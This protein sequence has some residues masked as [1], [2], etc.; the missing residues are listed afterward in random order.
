MLPT[1]VCGMITAAVAS[2]MQNNRVVYVGLAILV[3]GFVVWGFSCGELPRRFNSSGPTRCSG[4]P[5]GMT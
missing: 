2:I 1:M 3:M 4:T 5:L